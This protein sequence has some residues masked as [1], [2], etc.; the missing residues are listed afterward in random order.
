MPGQTVQNGMIRFQA[1]GPYFADFQYLVIRNDMGIPIWTIILPGDATDVKLPEF[2]DF[3]AL[4]VSE[5]PSPGADGQLYLSIVGARLDGGHVYERF[6]YR[7]VDQD[8]W[9]AYSLTSWLMRLR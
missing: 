9:Q 8:R 7:D 2:P 5:R 6:S 3:S 4:P 1:S